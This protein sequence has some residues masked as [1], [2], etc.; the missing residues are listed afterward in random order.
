MDG[1]ND[2]RVRQLDSSGVRDERDREDA[3][4]IQPKTETGVF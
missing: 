1:L 4:M 2:L 3:Q